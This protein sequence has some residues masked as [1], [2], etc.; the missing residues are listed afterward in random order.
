MK[1]IT[2]YLLFL[3]CFSIY[4]QEYYVITAQN[5]L[6]VRSEPNLSS[7]KQGKIPFGVVV[8]KVAE[9]NS[10]L[11]ITENGKEIKGNWVK[12]KYDNYL[13]LVSEETEPNQSE[14]Y[15][16]DAYL[17]K[18]KNENSI[19]I[20]EI[21]KLQFVEFLNN[22]QKPVRNLKKMSN[23]D[24]IKTFLKGRVDWFT[25]VDEFGLQREDAIKSITTENGQQLIINQRSN[26]YGF[27]QGVSGYYPD[28]DIL[29]LEGGHSIDVS[30]SIKT[31]GTYETIG[32]PE[33]II[34]SPKQTYR[35]NGFF[36][37]Q[38]CI[39]YFFQVKEG[40]DYTY[41]TEFNA[42]IDLCLFKE[43]YWISENEFIYIDNNTEAYFKGVIK[44]NPN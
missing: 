41:L 29:V 2:P 21:S 13:Y 39:T 36:G 38:E 25:G 37:G 6:N 14:G 23:L 16:F 32:N 42:D 1:I 7:E 3:V 8:Q 26:D 11:I 44:N 15:V 40:A 30:F 34:T 20:A 10:E 35:L 19:T 22:V 18:M 5:G 9:T 12:I 24:S 17:K 27:A 28:Y 4:S 43:F 31:G 33:Y